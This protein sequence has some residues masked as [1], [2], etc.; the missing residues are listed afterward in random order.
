[1]LPKI[2]LKMIKQ[3]ASMQSLER[4]E[5]YYKKGAVIEVVQRGD[6]VYAKVAGT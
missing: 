1:M 5:S 2:T 6:R 4:G 3:R